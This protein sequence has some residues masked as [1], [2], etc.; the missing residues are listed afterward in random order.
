MF[1]FVF[2]ATERENSGKCWFS[3]PSELDLLKRDYQMVGQNLPLELS[4]RRLVFFLSEECSRLGEKGL[5]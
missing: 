5:A 3:R 2:V 4:P 1:C